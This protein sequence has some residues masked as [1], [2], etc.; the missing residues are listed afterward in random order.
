MRQESPII[1]CTDDEF[2]RIILSSKNYSDALRKFGYARAHGGSYVTI[3]KRIEKLNIDTSHFNTYNK[4]MKFFSNDEIFVKNSPFKGQIRRRVLRDN[5]VP[6]K[7]AKCGN[8]GEWMG[9]PLTLT[10]DHINGDHNDNRIENLQFICPNCDS[11]QDTYCYKNK[12]KYVKKVRPTKEELTK[13]ILT[14]SLVKI[15][16]K[17]GVSDNAVR[18]WC[19][20]YDLPFRYNDIKNFKNN[21]V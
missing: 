18:K 16:K 21:A 5:L 19:K 10:L 13:D 3:K 14:L 20:K 15:G 6:Y 8:L 11:Q 2:K 17:Y 4:E 1:S 12:H 7:C 9:R